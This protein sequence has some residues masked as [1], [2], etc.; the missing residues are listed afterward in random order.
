[1]SLSQKKEST[2]IDTEVMK[3]MFL[4][5]SK[6]NSLQLKQII[7]R[8][9]IRSRDLVEQDPFFFNLP[10]GVARARLSPCSVMPIGDCDTMVAQ[11]VMH[12]GVGA[13]C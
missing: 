3:A 4:I 5:N 10:H 8:L 6:I 1:M 2:I 13:S 9:I 12:A 7:N 11:L